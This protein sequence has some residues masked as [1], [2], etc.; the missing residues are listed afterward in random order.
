[1]EVKNEL[2]LIVHFATQSALYN[3]EIVNIDGSNYP[4]ATIKKGGIEYRA[5]FEY[6]SS[7][8][9]AHGHD[10]RKCDLIICW[11]NDLLECPLPVIAL[12]DPDWYATPITPPSYDAKEAYYWKARAL[13]LEKKLK[14]LKQNEPDINPTVRCY[15]PE[16][17]SI[18]QRQEIVKRMDA[19]GLTLGQMAITLGVSV[20]TI[21]NDRKAIEAAF[22]I[23]GDGDLLLISQNGNE[24]S[25]ESL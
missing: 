17:L 8:F 11:E 9:N 13:Q 6:K 24:G 1:M 23:E 18:E 25:D 14:A 3:F 16:N 4:D 21:K 19:D 15:A 12:S 10:I 7:N 5:E 20:G 22:S 2:G